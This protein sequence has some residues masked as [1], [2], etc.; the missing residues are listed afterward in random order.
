MALKDNIME[1]LRNS[2]L[3][4]PFYSAFATGKSVFDAPKWKLAKDPKL[5]MALWN[6]IYAFPAALGLGYLVNNLSNQKAAAEVDAE[7]DKQLIDKLQSTRPRLVADPNLADTASFTD[8]PKKELNRL[9][10]IKD[11]ISKKSSS[12]F[13]KV[14]DSFV[15]LLVNSLIGAIPIGTA[16]AAATAGVAWSNKNNKE[17][18]KKDLE[19]RRTQLRNIQALIDHQMLANRGLIKGASQDSGDTETKHRGSELGPFEGLLNLPVLALALMSGAL[20]VATYRYM[21]RA[22]KNKSTIKYLKKTQLGSN[23]LQDTAQLS[24][25]DLPVDPN[26]V[27]ATPGDKKQLTLGEDSVKADSDPAGIVT[28]VKKKDALF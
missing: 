16:A 27:I 24:L 19:E 10:G 8:L 12:P 22:D 15:D 6:S 4:D 28:E 18:I 20:G 5:N 26:K 9:E 23:V 1:I 3:V 2:R 11:K 13:R 25:L 14:K 17:R 7:L 21:D